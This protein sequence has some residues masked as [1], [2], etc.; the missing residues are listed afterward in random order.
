MMAM[1]DQ[2]LLLCPRRRG[3]WSLEDVHRTLLGSSSWRDPARWPE[4]LPVICGGNQPELGLSNGDLGVKLGSGDAGRLLF[5][6]IDR[7]GHARMH[8][9]HPARLSALEPALALTI[10]RAQ[11]SEADHVSVLWPLQEGSDYDSCLLYTAI[12]RARGSLTLITSEPA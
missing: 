2:E 4:G 10:H 3:P 8:R 12:T 1:H 11:G 7:Q 5:R 9:L 6:V